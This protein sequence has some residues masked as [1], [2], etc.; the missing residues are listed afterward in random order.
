MDDRRT[1]VLSAGNTEYTGLSVEQSSVAGWQSALHAEDL[2]RYSEKWGI[3]DNY[4]KRAAEIIDRIRSLY[5]KSPTQRQLVEVD[6]ISS[7][8]GESNRQNRNTIPV[9]Y[10]K[11]FCQLPRLLESPVV[12]ASVV[13]KWERR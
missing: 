3:S 8:Q 7:R 9:E 10:R 1:G 2:A 13:L 12:N 6:G 11:L 4:G 5:K